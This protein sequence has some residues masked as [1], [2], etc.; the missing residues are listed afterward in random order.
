MWLL[1]EG[2]IHPIDTAPYQPNHSF[3]IYD[4]SAW[5]R[6][7]AARLFQIRTVVRE[8][9]APF[10]A[11]RTPAARLDRLADCDGVPV[12]VQFVDGGGGRA[13]TA[14]L[15]GVFG[16]GIDAVLGIEDEEDRRPAV[17]TNVDHDV[18]SLCTG[19]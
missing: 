2:V 7:A 12:A 18:G 15:L 17:V 16:A 9:W 6:Y 1:S 19:A 13:G 14:E 4:S 8:T 5:T 3:P 11:T 10:P